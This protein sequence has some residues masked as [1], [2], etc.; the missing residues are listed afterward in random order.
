MIAGPRVD[1]YVGR[2]KKHYCLPKLLLCHYS[3]YFQRCFNGNFI[4]ARNQKLNLPDDDVADFSILLEYMLHGSMPSPLEMELT[5][6]EA[7]TRCMAF[8]EYADKYNLGAIGDVI[9]E[10]LRKAAHKYGGGK[11]EVSHIELVFRVSPAD[12]LLRTLI[13]EAAL[14]TYGIKG[15]I[16]KFPK[17]LGETPG[18]AILLLKQIASRPENSKLGTML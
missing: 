14:S 6:Q 5:G 12:S 10:P 17:Q 9:C 13:A 18:F 1:I 11:I 15:C 2:A 8:L 4:E 16:S 3:D 7:I